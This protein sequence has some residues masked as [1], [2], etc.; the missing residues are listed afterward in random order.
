[1]SYDISR[2]SEED[3]RGWKAGVVVED[4]EVASAEY[5]LSPWLPNNDMARMAAR[6]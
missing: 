1:M 5:P 6:E 2:R 4:M 3:R